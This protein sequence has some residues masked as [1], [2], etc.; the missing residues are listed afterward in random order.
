VDVKKHFDL[1]FCRILAD[2]TGLSRGVL[3]FVFNGGILR[4]LK[5]AQKINL[6]KSLQKTEKG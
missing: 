3:N 2:F 1:C 5:T 6:I 4:D